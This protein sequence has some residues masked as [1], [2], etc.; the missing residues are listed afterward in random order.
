MATGKPVIVVLTGG[1][2][3]AVPFASA[4][5]AALLDV[6]YPGEEGGDALADVLFG[7]ANPAG[8][9][10]VTFY[11]RPP[12]CRPS[13]TTPCAGGPTAISN[14]RRSTLSA[15]G[16]RTR[17]FATRTSP[18]RPIWAA[19]RSTC[20]TSERA[21]ATRWSGVRRA[22]GCARVC[23][24]ALAGGVRPRRAGGR[25]AAHRLAAAAARGARAGG[26]AGRP[27]RHPG[28]GRH[29]RRGRS[30]GRRRPVSRR[31]PRPGGPGRVPGCYGRSK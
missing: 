25:R 30:A 6:W 17:G 1:S 29:R 16:C 24:A 9:L 26:R 19:C 8:R 3:L 21:R 10:P 31:R 22:A 27:P 5:A 20:K 23:A 11:G 12:I 7:D 14:A 15:S 2:A 4:H 13:P 18:S 28:G